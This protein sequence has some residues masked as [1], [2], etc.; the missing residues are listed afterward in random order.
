MKGV[1]LAGGTGSRMKP[2]TFVTNKH[3]LPIYTDKGAIPMVFYPI[4]TLVG[5]G[6][7]DILIISSR[8]HSGPII[9]NLGDGFSFGA[10]FTYK[11]QDTKRVDMGIASALKL[12]KDFTRDEPFSV[13]LGDNFFE[14]HFLSEFSHFAEA[15]TSAKI[16]VKKVPDPNRFGVYHDGSIEEKPS[17][18][19]SD[20]AVTGLYLYRPDVYDV[21][22]SLIPSVR[23]ELEVTDINQHYCS[24]GLMSVSEIGGFWSDMGTPAS[25]S[26]TQDF[27]NQDG[28][29][30]VRGD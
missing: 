22:D 29:S 3:L 9:Q 11:V 10:D 13:I 26:R 18:P 7:K 19:K 12:A 14:D 28:R 30:S 4:D 1:I 20:M 24:C 23:G 25:I 6:I 16:F 2:A 27:L 21:A 17:S 5:S 15:S 8:E